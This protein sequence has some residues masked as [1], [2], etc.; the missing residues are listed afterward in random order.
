MNRIH[1]DVI[2]Q[3]FSLLLIVLLGLI[4]F[5]ELLPYLS[6][7]LGAVTLY[8]ISKKYMRKMV[9]KG[10]NP[11]LAASI[12]MIISFVGIM[13]PVGMVF[14]M[15]STKVKTALTK[16]ERILSLLQEQ[17]AAVEQQL[18]IHILSSMDSEETAKWI[19][20]NIQG[21]LGNTFN[22]IIAL[23]IMYFL[24]YYMLVYRKQ[25][26]ESIYT[27]FPM[28][29]ENITTLG[30]EIYSMVK[31][32]AIGI[33]IIAVIQGFVAL[34]G[35]YIFDIPNPWFWFVITAIGS[36]IPF[37]GTA[38]GILP[39]VIIMFSTGQ[40]F[41]AVGILLYGLL[42]VGTSDNLFRMVVQKKLA[43]IHPLI[44]LI[45]VIIGVPLFG[46]I[47]LIFGPLL[48]SLFLLVLKIYKEEF[49]IRSDSD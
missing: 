49:V 13:L 44:T 24:L 31:S 11:S 45:G 39:V 12:I 33:P 16:L 10:W 35:F 46:F 20:E 9:L 42:V 18:N 36:M 25:F 2:R 5:F 6:G 32:N 34:I 7:V 26:I 40:N 8:I 23:S 19:S 37:V 43:D 15:L 30:N 48:I 38:V 3:V 14:M 21:I 22:T 28:R 4:I 41:Q 17:I 29:P 1:Q 27:Y 47:G